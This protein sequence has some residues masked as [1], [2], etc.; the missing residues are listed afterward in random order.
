MRDGNWHNG[1]GDSGGWWIL[2]VIMM[3][4]FWGGLIWI[5][6]TLLKHNHQTPQP[7]LPNAQRPGQRPTAQE[8]LAELCQCLLRRSPRAK[9]LSADLTAR[10]RL[11]VETGV[12]AEPPGAV[13]FG[14]RTS[15][16]WRTMIRSATIL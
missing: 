14:H 3:I 6:I 13:A 8:I 9:A 1:M 11:G 16:H 15:R 12:Y 10:P 7:T 2:M 5:G 4:A